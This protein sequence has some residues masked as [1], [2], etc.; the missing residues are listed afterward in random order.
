MVPTR[1]KGT[2]DRPSS[3]Q[4]TLAGD[5]IC[6]MSAVAWSPTACPAR[7]SP[8]WRFGP[9]RPELRSPSRASMTISCSTCH[10]P[11]TTRTDAQTTPNASRAKK[12]KLSGKSRPNFSSSSRAPCMRSRFASRSIRGVL[13]IAGPFPRRDHRQ[14]RRTEPVPTTGVGECLP[15]DS[16]EEGGAVGGGVWAAPPGASAS[17]RASGVNVDSKA[18]HASVSPQGARALVFCGGTAPHKKGRSRTGDCAPSCLWGTMRRKHQFEGL[19]L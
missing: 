11:S 7:R 1:R 18:C 14:V 17:C 8:G 16:W 3:V 4:L 12:V 5:A 6:R 10:S 13:S 19:V 2:L 9:A 15:R